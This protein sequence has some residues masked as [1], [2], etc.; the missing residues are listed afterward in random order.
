VAIV[1]GALQRLE[2]ASSLRAGR[3]IRIENAA[4]K[5][6]KKGRK[7]T[8]MTLPFKAIR[9]DTGADPL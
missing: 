4:K 1:A 9:A 7:K 2:A 6:R 8:R 3:T 5:S